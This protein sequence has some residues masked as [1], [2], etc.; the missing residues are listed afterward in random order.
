[1][2]LWAI[3]SWKLKTDEFKKKLRNRTRRKQWLRE[4]E[5]SNGYG[6]D[7]E[8]DIEAHD[9]SDILSQTTV[10]GSDNA[11]VLTSKK[12]VG[13]VLLNIYVQDIQSALSEKTKKLVMQ[14]MLKSCMYGST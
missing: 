4:Q 3:K 7:D 13:V 5:T 9:A 10:T 14:V 8:L 1:M 6:D 12:P 11:A 2:A